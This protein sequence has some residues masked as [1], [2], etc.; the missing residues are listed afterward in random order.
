[1]NR[2][3]NL[4]L[5]L[6]ENSDYRDVSQL[7]YNFSTLDTE[8][9]KFSPTVYEGS[10][11]GSNQNSGSLNTDTAYTKAVKSGKVVTL[12]LRITVPTISATTVVF[13]LVSALRPYANTPYIECFETWNKTSFRSIV[14]INSNGNVLVQSE[15]SGKDISFF[16]TYITS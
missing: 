1:M 9:G 5:Y 6:P 4:N 16:A 12:W 13:K 10:S 3:T 7:T 2:S 15:A 8:A 14:S 11:I